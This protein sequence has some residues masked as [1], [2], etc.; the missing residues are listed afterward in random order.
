PAVACGCAVFAMPDIRWDL[1]TRRSIAPMASLMARVGLLETRLTLSLTDEISDAR[2]YPD[3]ECVALGAVTVVPCAFCGMGGCA[4]IGQTVINLSSGGRGRLSGVVAGL[5]IRMFVLFLS[6]LIERIP[7][8]AS[9]GAMFVVAQQTF[10]WA[11]L[12]VLRKVPVNDA[13]AIIAVTVV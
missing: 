5:M 11:S 8:A 4:M 9:G 10:A 1:E 2:G 12:R 13:L 6:P 7:L 3:R